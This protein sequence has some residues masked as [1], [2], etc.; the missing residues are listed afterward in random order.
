MRCRPEDHHGGCDHGHDGYNYATEPHQ[1]PGLEYERSANLAHAD[2]LRTAPAGPAAA[3][4]CLGIGG[5]CSVRG[6][7]AEDLVE[8][9]QHVRILDGVVG[10]A[11]LAPGRNDP[12][13]A[14]LGP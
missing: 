13:Q 7:V 2:P 12:S 11:T 3:L 8:H 6:D 14:Q 5:Q 1:A 9:G 4:P 10:V